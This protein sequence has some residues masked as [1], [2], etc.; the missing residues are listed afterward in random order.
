[1]NQKTALIVSGCIFAAV[2]LAHLLRLLLKIE[3]LVSGA[4]LPMG[5]SVVGLVI[6]LVLSIWMF[7]AS[8]K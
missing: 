6:A 4:L 7:A 1:M 8:R 5:V 3:I 2:A